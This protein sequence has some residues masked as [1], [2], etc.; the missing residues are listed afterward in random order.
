MNKKRLIVA[1]LILFSLVTLFI[2]SQAW[3]GSNTACIKC[4]SLSGRTD[5]NAEIW[6]ITSGLEKAEFSID[7]EKITWTEKDK[8]HA[9]Y[10][11]DNGVFTIRIEGENGLYVVFWAIPS[12][13]KIIRDTSEGL[14]LEFK[15]NLYGTEPRKDKG[16][17]SPTIELSCTL[18]YAV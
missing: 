17:I 15:A 7:G 2:T 13:F 5:F 11:P 8:A 10:D 14:K 18:D 1:L 12:T 4:K 16:R 9:V 6:N 3:A